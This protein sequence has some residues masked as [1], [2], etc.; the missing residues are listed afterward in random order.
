MEHHHDYYIGGLPGFRL[1][2]TLDFR[3]LDSWPCFN[4]IQL[5]RSL[6]RN[7][8]KNCVNQKADKRNLKRKRLT[9]S[10]KALNHFVLQLIVG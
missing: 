10:L 2:K 5:Q 3:T 1:L 8:R 7:D 4:S 6:R 9:R